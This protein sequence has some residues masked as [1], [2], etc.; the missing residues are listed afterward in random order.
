VT[1]LKA[2]FVT[3]RERTTDPL[4]WPREARRRAVTSND[5][6]TVEAA[7]PPPRADFGFGVD[8]D[9]SPMTIVGEM[10]KLA[11]N[12]E[13]GRMFA[14]VH[15]RSDSSG[16]LLGEAYAISYLVDILGDYSPQFQQAATPELRLHKFDGSFLRITRFGQEKE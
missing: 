14:G 2:F 4:P 12:V 5:G 15:Y 11:Q 13:M 10:N 7:V 16:I 1:V 9:S 8:V 3:H 6:Q